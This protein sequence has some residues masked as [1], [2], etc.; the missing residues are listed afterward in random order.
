MNQLDLI[1]EIMEIATK[2]GCIIRQKVHT[3]N[4][5]GLANNGRTIIYQVR[6]FGGWIGHSPIE[7]DV[8]ELVIDLVYQTKKTMKP[9]INH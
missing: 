4:F 1:D 6:G 3:D 7:Y 5:K 8:T 2:C 9:L